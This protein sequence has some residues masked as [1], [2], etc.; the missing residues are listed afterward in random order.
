M[1]LDN[2][3]AGISAAGEF[4]SSA[5]PFVTSSQA[6]VAS[7]GA[8]RIDLPKV[9]RFLTVA[10]H[11]AAANLLRVGF[12]LNGVR[13]AGNY[14]LVA[15]GGVPV[16]LELRVK[17]VFF[18]GHTTSPSFSLCAGLTTVDARDMSTL[19]GTLPNGAPGWPGVG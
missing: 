14:F 19:S 7:T 17:E 18:A 4:Q 8:L 2:P 11:D 1:G 15:G 9:T 16:T 3:R 12:T 5:L 10:N 13:N 6:P